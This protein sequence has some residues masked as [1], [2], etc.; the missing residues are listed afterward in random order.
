LM[1]IW[2]VISHSFSLDMTLGHQIFMI[3]RKHLFTKY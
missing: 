2:L 3:Y 1:F